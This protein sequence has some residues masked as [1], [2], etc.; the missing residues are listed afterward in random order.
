[1]KGKWLCLALLFCAT[2]LLAVIPP[3]VASQPLPTDP[4]L[5]Q[6]VL[7]NGLKYYIMR[8]AKPEK[9]IEVRLVVDAG[10]VNEDDDQQGLAHFTEHMAFNGSKNFPRTEMVEYLT[11]IGMGYHNGLNGGTTYDNTTYMFKLP[12]DDEKKLRK[13]FSI[14]SDIAWQLSMDDSEIDRER[15]VILEE[16]R[17]GQ[18]AEQRL[19][20]VIDKVRMAGSR[21]A[22]RNPIGKEALL[23]SFKHDSLKRYYRDWYRPDL[24]TVMMVGDYDPQAMEAMVKEYFSVIPKRDN[25]RPK[26]N[27]PV[28]DNPEPRAVVALDKELSTGNVQI[29]WKKEIPAN[30]TLGT[31]Y[32]DL[33]RNLFFTMFNMRMQEIS[34]KPDTPFAYAYAFSY[35]WLKSFASDFMLA[36]FNEGRSEDALRTLMTEATRIKQHGFQKGEFDRAKQQLIRD[37]E[38]TV[39]AKPTRD[40]GRLTWGIIGPLNKGDSILSPEQEE[41]LT[42]G[43]INE[44]RLDE[45]NAI[46]SDIISSQNMT[47]SLSGTD[48]PGAVYPSEKQML[49]IFHEVQQTLLEPWVDTTVNEPIMASMPTPGK[50]TKEKTYPRSGIKQWTLSNGINVYAKQ[51]D[52][53]A[54]EV[55]MKAMSPGGK[56][57]L[58]SGEAKA[59][60]LLPMYLD[61]AGFGNFDGPALQKALAGKVAN[62]N[63][64]VETY[65]DELQGSCSPKDLELMFQLTNQYLTAPRDDPGAFAAAVA[66]IRPFIQNAQLDP[67]TVFDDSL[68]MLKYNHHPLKA[69]LHAEDLDNISYSEFLKA[70]KDRYADLSDFSFFVVGAFDEA[71]LKE[72]CKTY[73]AT[74]PASKKNQDYMKDAGIRSFAGNKE[75]KFRNGSS[76]RFFESTVTTGNYKFT[77]ENATLLNTLM[78]ISYEKLRENVRENLSGAYAVVIWQE[79][80]HFPKPEVSI[81]TWLGCDP[82]RA[83]ALNEATFA[84]LDSI[85]LGQFDNKYLASAKTT[86]LKS[87]EEDIKSNRYWLAKMSDNA[88]YKLPIDGFVDYPKL[89]ARIDRKAVVKAANQY[90]TFDKNKLTVIMLPET[91]PEN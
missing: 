32:N 14:L 86:M 3:E 45:V 27:Y 87:F 84:T 67:E 83:E 9:R 89:Y 38:N 65:D 8:N 47:I 60:D 12:T 23:R 18:R 2:V 88:F 75:V 53:K 52:F 19:N 78:H 68:T 79:L 69:S 11:S 29:T 70:F 76:D 37:A 24:E 4:D 22:E 28:P 74:L 63:L 49:D 50:I 31:W 66:R 40:S 80:T 15:G 10:S 41:A 6:G 36:V 5:V 64:G 20:D 54:D 44:I 57:M 46:I 91:P 90:L 16:W 48:K 82:E 81:N 34:M 26:E 13:G 61:S 30:T 62:V 17:L 55:M 71:A 77:V 56:A 58:N 25:P 42:K 73:L 39:A 59:V 85:R 43:M 1:M 7:P 51:T 35:N 72:Y 33:K 21:Y